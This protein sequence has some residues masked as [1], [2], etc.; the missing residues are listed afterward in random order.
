MAI[1]LL[2]LRAFI[3]CK[4]GETYHSNQIFFAST[5]TYFDQAS[6]QSELIRIITKPKAIPSQALTGP[7]GSRRLR[8]PDFKT[9]SPTYWPP[10]PPGP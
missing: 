6:L 1:P 7:E 10:L 3:A 5:P 8:L 4:K 2:S 9:I